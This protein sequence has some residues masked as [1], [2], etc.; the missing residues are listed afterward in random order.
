MAEVLLFHHAQ[1]RTEGFEAFAD[2]LRR[3][4][5]TVHTPDLF[6]GRSFASIE[7]GVAYASQIGF[8]EEIIE[9]GVEA[10]NGLADELVYAAALLTQRVLE[11]LRTR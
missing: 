11:F 1:G 6:D 8:P 4:G 2:E 9:R 3:G 10:A 7:E 5:H